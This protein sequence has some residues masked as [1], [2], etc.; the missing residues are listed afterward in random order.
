MPKIEAGNVQGIMARKARVEFA[1][2]VHHVLDR[3]DRKRPRE[4]LL[5]RSRAGSYPGA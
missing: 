5:T 2:A 4:V 3:G 1:G